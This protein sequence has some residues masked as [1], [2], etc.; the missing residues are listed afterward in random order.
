MCSFASRAAYPPSHYNVSSCL[1]SYGSNSSPDFENIGR[2][3]L[4]LIRRILQFGN[5]LI[6]S[7][8]SKLDSS[9]RPDV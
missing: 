1:V 6:S 3:A 2:F 9:R 5:S 7:T 8:L 4:G